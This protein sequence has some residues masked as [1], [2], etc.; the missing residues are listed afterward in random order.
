[1][2]ALLDA[3]IAQPTVVLAIQLEKRGIPTASICYGPGAQLAAASSASLIEAL[4]LHTVNVMRTAGQDEMRQ[5]ANRLVTEVAA[6][7]T[8][9]EE[10]IKQ[11]I[12]AGRAALPVPC[13]SGGILEL[14]AQD[15]TAR[16]TRLM[17]DSGVGD[18][19]PLFCPTIHGVD[20]LLSE[21]GVDPQF[22]GGRWSHLDGIR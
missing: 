11:W 12:D 4:S 6:G 7:L 20:K 9:G 5:E 15:A 17:L 2:F 10:S 8:A 1:M 19:F 21:A 3:G 14:E 22:E 13:V 16:F 18:G